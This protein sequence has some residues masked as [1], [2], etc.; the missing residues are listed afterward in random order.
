M[1]TALILLLLLG[2]PLQAVEYL[3]QST[4][5]T[6]KLGP[7]VD[8]ADGVTAEDSLTISQADIRLSKN[9]GDIAQTNNASGA[10]HDELG[11]YNV[12]LNTTD[13]NTLG[14]LRVAVS[15]SG[16]L[17]VWQD[18]MVVPANVYGALVQG[19]HVL[20]AAAS[21]YHTVLRVKPTDDLHA[22]AEAA[23]T[24]T[25]IALESGTHDIGANVLTLPAGVDIQGDFGATIEGDSAYVLVL[26]GRT[27]LKGFR[28]QANAGL[29]FHV[30][31]M[32]QN[33]FLFEDLYIRG[34]N[35]SGDAGT[36]DL[37][38]VVGATS[39]RH[40]VIIR[41][42]VFDTSWW[43]GL[44][45]AGNV[46]ATISDCTF[47][48]NGDGNGFGDGHKAIFIL[49]G[50]AN[51]Q[52]KLTLDNVRWFNNPTTPGRLEPLC[53]LSTQASGTKIDVTAINCHVFSEDHIV[54]DADGAG[55]MVTVLDCGGNNFDVAKFGIENPAKFTYTHKPAA[56]ANTAVV[57]GA[58]GSNSATAATQS[59]TAATQ[60]TTAATQ[61]AAANTAAAGARTAAETV[62]NRLTAPR[63]GNLDNLDETISGI[64]DA[65]FAAEFPE[66]PAADSLAEWLAGL[67]TSEGLEQLAQ[68]VDDA[69]EAGTT[70]PRVND[71]AG[72][73]Y[74][75]DLVSM[76][77]GTYK[78]VGR[79]TRA[80]MLRPGE[81]LGGGIAVQVFTGKVFGNVKVQT[82]H[83]PVM[84]DGTAITATELGPRD[85]PD[86]SA[87]VLLDGTPAPSEETDCTFGITMR[88]G[89]RVPVTFDIKVFAE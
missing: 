32:A 48:A 49:M 60:S 23:T 77:D 86:P 56:D 9:G 15:E 55:S 19:S 28:I 81:I 53:Y 61:S 64:P 18:F 4:A 58:V 69:V 5:A 50:G 7:F 88:T 51:E 39:G 85:A 16:A 45:L 70:Q 54:T 68:E 66:T 62:E 47:I 78:A 79:V 14:R 22:I 38:S 20:R 89:E 41:H 12:P 46:N 72:R 82:V 36:D 83:E 37:C 40:N 34:I 63:A 26:Q 13:T 87:M 80:A 35:A 76:A 25:L 27:H 3:S 11:Y 10:T 31:A 75:F 57:A 21:G 24:G 42:C 44:L 2:Q 67:A 30:P 84:G 43:D 29:A 74:Q 73:S 59:T 71:D 17:P 6:I 33:D 1:R 65:I 8:A 52:L